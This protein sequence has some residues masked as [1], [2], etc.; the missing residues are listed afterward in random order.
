MKTISLCMIVK[1]EA[2][3]ILR[4]LNSVR[5]L[6]DYVLIED[7]GSTDGTQKLIQGWLDQEGMPGEVFDEEWR[8]FAHN[9]TVALTR[10]RD[11]KEID[12]TLVMDADDVLLY[13]DG[14]EPALFKAEL[15]S[16]VY[17]ISLR[18]DAIKHHRA[19]LCSNRREFVYRGVVHEFLVPP[20][21]ASSA[22]ATG[23]YIFERR[24]G[25]RSR[26]PEKYRKDATVLEFALSSESDAFMRSRYTF[27]LAQS[28]RDC[29]DIEK[30]LAVYLE[31]AEL[32]YWDEEVFVSV[33][34]AAKLMER[35]GR[36][37]DE[38]LGMYLRAWEGCP[39]RAEALHGAAHYCLTTGRNRQG[40][41]FARQGLEIPQPDSG[42]FV[43]TWIYDYGLL[44]ELAVNGYWA[45][46]FRE[47]LNACER[48][49]AEAKIPADMRGRVEN[50]AGYARDK[51]LNSPDNPDQSMPTAINILYRGAIGDILASS[52][53]TAQL[54]ALHSGVEICYYTKYPQI[55]KLLAGVG[56]VFDSDQWDDRKPGM[57]IAPWSDG[58]PGQPM[59]K[60]LTTYYC[61]V[62][63]LPPGPPK[64]KEELEP[65][66][67]KHSRWVTI[68]PASGWSVYKE[69]G[70]EKW[71]EIILRM[72]Q[73]YPE[74][75]VVQIGGSADDPELHGTDYDLRGKT[76]I[77]QALWLIKQSVLHLG[78]D[79]FSNHAAGA[80][81][82]PAVILFGSTSPTG[83]GYASAV[84]LW[85]GL[86]CSPCYRL[87]P[88]L[89]SNN[90][91]SC[92]NPPN[93]D[94]DHP[95]HACMTAIT[96]D[97]VWPWITR[98]LSKRAAA[99]A[100][101]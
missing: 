3:V 9:R 30:A 4:C 65:V 56:S 94:Y 53:V 95:R 62:A 73:A 61:E 18:S 12:Y 101:Q 64:L 2:H 60:H 38:V 21:D 82:H 66:D 84:N 47:S 68:H 24:E 77:S 5:R 76:S 90:G 86:D 6:V 50:N 75:G 32:G 1:N 7:T 48:L 85:A 52:A 17:N 14:F 27:Y 44:D 51:L 87:N 59:R 74:L 54:A 98:L 91:G 69:W 11:R 26:D 70:V 23:L 43:E 29:G 37:E 100:R 20:D 49:L 42:L 58:A 25:A 72:H 67:I 8:D 39:H 79:S 78:I 19:A 33:Y 31:R 99:N 71:N 36:P 92:K 35:L 46:R 83:Y 34:Q 55:A 89:I 41:M 40:Y 22:M 15:N 93:Q 63:G 96:V 16:D 88:R 81:R 57:D 45:E 13:D 10:L 28:W 97:D 80:L